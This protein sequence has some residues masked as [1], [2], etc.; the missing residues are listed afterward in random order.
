MF[1]NCLGAAAVLRSLSVSGQTDKRPNILFLLADDT[2]NMNPGSFLPMEYDYTRLKQ[3]PD[4]WQP[5]YTL[6]KFFKGTG[7]VKIE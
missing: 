6:K 7:S 5:E 3:K 2:S 4:Q 1:K